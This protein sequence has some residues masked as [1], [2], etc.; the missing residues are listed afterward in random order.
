MEEIFADST[1]K[2]PIIIVLSAG[3][4]PMTDI[5]NL[6]TLKK[7]KFESLSLGQGQGQKAVNEIKKA[8]QNQTWVVLQNCHLAPSFMPTLDGLIEEIVRDPSSQ[9]RIWL[10]T[11]PS[12]K[13]PVTIV[14]NG[15]KVTAEPP[16]GLRN[17]VRGFYYTFDNKEFE[18]SK[19]PIAFRRL[20]W[21]LVF[22][23]ALILERRKFGPLGW[24]IPYE[25]SVSDLRISKDQLAQFLDHYD[26]IPYEALVYMVAEA[27][28]GGRVTDPQDRR[29]IQLILSDFYCPEMISESNHKLSESG[30]YFVPPDGSKEDYISF[31][32]Q[33]LPI[34]DLTEIFG[35]HDNAEIT[36]AINFTQNMLATALSLQPRAAGAGG[37]SQDQ[38]L[39]ENAA[40]ILG[41]LPMPFNLE[42]AQKRHPITYD[43]SMNT[44]LLQELLRFNK[45]LELVRSSLS[46]I[47]KAI[48]G[49]V[50]MSVELEAIGN[51]IFDNRTPGTWMKRSYPS[52]KPLA[53]YIVDFVERLAFMQKWVDEGAPSSFWI[54]GFFFTQSFL[55]GIK[56]NYA[57]KY[58]IAIDEIDL[59]FEPF[60]AKNGYK[61]D[62]APKDGAFIYGLYLEGCR[63]DQENSYLAESAPKVLFTKMPPIYFKPANKKDIVFPHCYTC[64]VYKTLDRRGTLSTTGHSTNF[65]VMIEMNMQKR[66][67]MKHWVKR[68]VA[69]ITQLND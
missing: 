2:Q 47:G 11:M 14:Q 20:L 9:F 34:N 45:L 50:V 4:D 64:P 69:L 33:R 37:K 21:G 12:D 10:T 6:S 13:F 5:R 17:N 61:E 42:Y 28:Y 30:A 55:T 44:V 52:L 66:H 59:D 58:V 31:I 26:E 8:Q 22:F 62:E 53:S 29:A 23:N 51:S 56:Q 19:K 63:W 16:K 25:F 43:E 46:N 36:S 27:N 3:A 48:R 7:I 40:E 39:A 60:S 68:G 1:N 24:N 41:K 54:S 57:R 18:E 49:E 15:V 32:E 65:V 35:M 38:V 67:T